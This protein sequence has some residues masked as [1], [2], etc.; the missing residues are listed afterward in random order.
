MH[1]H[2]N[3]HVEGPLLICHMFM[4]SDWIFQVY[5]A[6]I[7]GFHLILYY[8]VQYNA[9]AGVCEGIFGILDCPLWENQKGQLVPQFKT[10][11]RVTA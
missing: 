2:Q 1:V 7:L 8:I 3:T 6:D 10:S 4:S 5:T 9:H 11:P